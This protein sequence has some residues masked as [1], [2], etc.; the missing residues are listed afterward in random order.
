MRDRQTSVNTDTINETNGNTVFFTVLFYQSSYEFDVNYLA[1]ILFI[2]PW[3]LALNIFVDG[4]LVPF[5]LNDIRPL[6]A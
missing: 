3:F 6:P 2:L 4:G 1:L 5:F